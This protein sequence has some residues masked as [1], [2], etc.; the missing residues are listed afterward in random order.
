MDYHLVQS[1]FCLQR[2]Q[3]IHKGL[4]YSIKYLRK[5]SYL[6][7]YDFNNKDLLKITIDVEQFGVINR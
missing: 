1:E 6:R 3:M 2:D 4:K 7:V 5:V